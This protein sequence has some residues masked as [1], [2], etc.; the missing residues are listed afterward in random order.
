MQC[1]GTPFSDPRG[2]R[3]ETETDGYSFNG[4]IIDLDAPNPI[5]FRRGENAQA[6]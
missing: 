3:M 1:C 2:K 4:Y 6:R 5:P